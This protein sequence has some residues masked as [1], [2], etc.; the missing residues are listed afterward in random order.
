M[1]KQFRH[2]EC[3]KFLLWVAPAMA[4]SFVVL[5]TLVI[6]AAQVWESAAEWAEAQFGYWEPIVTSTWFLI[7]AA[8]FIAGYL[9]GLI[10][11]SGV[12]EKADEPL[13]E[14]GLILTQAEGNAVHFD[15]AAKNISN[16]T[17]NIASGVYRS[18]DATLFL[19]GSQ[20]KYVPPG[21][22]VEFNGG[23]MFPNEKRWLDVMFDLGMG[24]N[25]KKEVAR[26][27]FVIPVGVSFPH[28]IK[29]ESWNP[30]HPVEGD[31]VSSHLCDGLGQEAGTLL[32]IFPKYL[33]DKK[34]LN[35]V[36]MGHAGK[37]LVVDATSMIGEFFVRF[38]SDAKCVRVDLDDKEFQRITAVWDTQ[39]MR[40]S[41]STETK[42]GLPFS[43]P[44]TD[45]GA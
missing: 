37:Q 21:G 19:N 26:Y 31:I 23:F 12:I 35:R 25:G 13:L 2:P 7:L 43:V 42:S 40:V 30:R 28:R 14:I 1:A 32:F 27:R 8:I 10:F 11:C 9:A 6:A 39:S 20:N 45:T 44:V 24:R 29:P 5:A 41:L 17:I 33:E 16:S 15:V 18:S 4:G 34:T 38:G 36:A 3:R 22:E